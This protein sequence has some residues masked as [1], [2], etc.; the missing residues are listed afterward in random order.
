[1]IASDIIRGGDVLWLCASWWIYTRTSVSV[2]KHCALHTIKLL[3]SPCQAINSLVFSSFISY[4]LFVFL[5]SSTTS[6]FHFVLVFFRCRNI[7]LMSNDYSTF[8][9]STFSCPIPFWKSLC[10]VEMWRR[11]R[12]QLTT[13]SKQQT[14]I[15]YSE[16]SASWRR[17]PVCSLCLKFLFVFF[18]VFV[19]QDIFETVQYRTMN[20]DFSASIRLE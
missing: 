1:M 4:I 5:K 19:H 17:R 6:L 20:H 11:V 18:Y 14:Q 16:H 13:K 12:W 2:S 7:T 15:N 10:D 9:L 3:E 8:I